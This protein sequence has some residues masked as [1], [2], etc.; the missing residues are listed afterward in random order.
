MSVDVEELP[1]GV[2]ESLFSARHWYSGQHSALYSWASSGSPV[3][4]LAAEARAAAESAER[5]AERMAL[6]GEEL[7]E[8]EDVLTDCDALAAL[9]VW[10]ER[11]GL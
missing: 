9:A 4:G 7:E 3:S 5:L 10:A 1:E 6:G 2:A 11:R 8:L